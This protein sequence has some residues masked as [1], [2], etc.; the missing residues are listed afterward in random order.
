MEMCNWSEDHKIRTKE[1]SGCQM[2]KKQFPAEIQSSLVTNKEYFLANKDSCSESMLTSSK[3]LHAKHSK[4][5]PEKLKFH[6]ADPQKLSRQ[7]T[8]ENI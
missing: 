8:K 2:I 4:K 1:D 6:L 5:S 3:K 7:L